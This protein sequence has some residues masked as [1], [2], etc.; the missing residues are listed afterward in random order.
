MILVAP[1]HTGGLHVV[2]ANGGEMEPVTTP[3]EGINHWYPSFLPGGRRFLFLQEDT[4]ADSVTLLVGSLDTSGLTLVPGIRSR[5]VYREGYLFFTRGHELFAQRFDTDQ[6]VGMDDP[7]RM[8]GAVGESFGGLGNGAFSIETGMLAYANGGS[9]PETQLLAVD[10]QGRR[11]GPIG[12][13][14][15]IYGF[16]VAPNERTA[17]LE[18]WDPVTDTVN[19]WLADLT[20]GERTRF[21]FGERWNGFPQ[22]SPDGNRLVFHAAPDLFL[23]GVG[24][25]PP[26]LVY[27]GFVFASDWSSDGQ[28]LVVVH[29]TGLET[30]HDLWLHPRFAGEPTVYLDSPFKEWEASVSPNSKWL[31]YAS[32]EDG[33]FAVYVDSMPQRG[34]MQRVG[35]GEHPLWRPDGEALYYL[36]PEAR[37][38]MV[39]T[40]LTSSTLQ[41][42]PPEFLFEAPEVVDEV[43]RQYAVL[44]NGDRFIFNA[45][46]EDAEPRS[47]TIVRNWKVLL[48]D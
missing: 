38:M 19:V 45:V 10:R 8:A 28:F 14:G 32:D 44:D 12:Q 22:W 46:Y 1:N 37:L 18:M 48:E 24:G 9:I 43:R 26:E 13:P 5:A 25:G 16:T 29:D 3:E 35:T 15:Y 40:R 34:H 36:T 2:S 31:A 23:R 4:A 6:L 30:Q 33:A 17:A 7:I 47:I 21:T 11:L 41:I 42:S 27:E 39:Q 20:T